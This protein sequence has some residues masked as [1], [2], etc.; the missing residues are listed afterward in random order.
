MGYRGGLG[1]VV[2]GLVDWQ[3]VHPL[4]NSVTLSLMFGHQ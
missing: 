3:V 2:R 1:Y 4:T